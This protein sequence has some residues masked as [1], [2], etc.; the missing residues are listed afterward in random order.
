[1]EEINQCLRNIAAEF[2][3]TDLQERTENLIA[4][5]VNIL[6]EKL[7]FYRAK[8]QD[9]R[10][11]IEINSFCSWS[12]ISAANSFG[13]EVI[14]IGNKKLHQEDKNRLQQWLNKDNI[15][16][17]NESFEEIFQIINEYQAD[18]LIASS[19]LQSLAFQ[20]KIPFL[21]INSEINHSYT[22]YAGILAA[23]QDL[24]ATIYNPVW[25]QVRKPAPWEEIETNS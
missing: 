18:L 3:D 4:E 21:N 15:V 20:A 16:L 25:Q 11:I 22:G 7:V 10:V 5:E 1:V 23:A 2:G 19:Y 17:V 12:I 13:M 9:K 8:L 14:P 6:E 24:Y